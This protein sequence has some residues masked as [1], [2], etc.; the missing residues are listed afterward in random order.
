MRYTA[1][2][3]L[4]LGKKSRINP[5]LV[6]G[7]IYPI[8][9]E[10]FNI[11]ESQATYVGDF[12][13]NGFPSSQTEKPRH[14]FAH[15]TQPWELLSIGVLTTTEYPN[16]PQST[17]LRWTHPNDSSIGDSEIAAFQVLRLTGRLDKRHLGDRFHERA[18]LL[19]TLVGEILGNKEVLVA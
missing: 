8:I 11:F 14:V 3:G 9:H 19:E 17:T 15:D 4:E 7:R 13:A 6:V 16:S 18:K 1:L 10:E 2:N 5:Q 12:F